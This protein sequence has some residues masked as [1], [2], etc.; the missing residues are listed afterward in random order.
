MA[1]HSQRS[2]HSQSAM[3]YNWKIYNI[4]NQLNYSSKEKK[5]QIALDTRHS[6]YKKKCKCEKIKKRYI[7]KRKQWSEKTEKMKTEPNLHR[8]SRVKKAVSHKSSVC[9]AFRARRPLSRWLFSEVSQ[10]SEWSEWSEWVKW[11]QKGP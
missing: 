11:I 8:E 1:F 6:H 7:Q 10:W 3:L 9:Q 4:K 2:V 5:R